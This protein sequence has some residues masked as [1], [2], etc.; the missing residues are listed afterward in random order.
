MRG[1]FFVGDGWCFQEL[2][3][4]V[5]DRIG[6]SKYCLYLLNTLQKLVCQPLPTTMRQLFLFVTFC[7][8]YAACGQAA[9][10]LHVLQ[11]AHQKRIS[12]AGYTKETEYLLKDSSKYISEETYYR[13]DG[14]PK[15]SVYRWIGAN[16]KVFS[17]FH[18]DYSYDTS[19]RLIKLIKRDADIKF[20]PDS[21]T[22]KYDEKGREIMNTYRGIWPIITY[23][24]Y[25][26][27]GLTTSYDKHTYR[28]T[29]NENMIP[30]VIK[31]E[32]LYDKNGRLLEKREFELQGTK[33]PKEPNK[34]TRWTY[35]EKDWETQMAEFDS[36]GKE[37][38]HTSYTYNEL[39]L[40]VSR[41]VSSKEKATTYTY[42][43][44]KDCVQPKY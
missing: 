25:N 13:K 23:Y 33:K 11:T 20:Q 38:S 14:K 40:L 19:G 32:Y 41:T 34:I 12:D 42:E 44:C 24:K 27:K 29:K 8:A 2:S 21:T 37:T 39:G 26:K 30:L 10:G 6:C 4:T 5:D 35:N 17:S 22:F 36:L 1:G 31:G 43:Y 28:L 18:I 9:G 15:R 7:V 16:N 3:V